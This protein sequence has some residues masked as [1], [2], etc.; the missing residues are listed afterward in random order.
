MRD[1]LQQSEQ[2]LQ[3]L[4][5]ATPVGIAYVKDRVFQKVNDAM[6]DLYGYSREELIGQ[7]SRM[8]YATN[9]EY[10]EAGRHSYHQAMEINS[11]MV[12]TH[13]ITKQGDKIDILMGIAPLVQGDE[14]AG[15]VTVVLDITDRNK[16]IAALKESEERF[17]TIFNESP[18]VIALND[19]SNGGYVDVNRKF[20][21]IRNNSRESF[22]GKT[23]V[24][25]G[26]ISEE[27]N[28]RLQ[29][30]F[31]EKGEIDQEEISFVDLQGNAS[32]FLLYSKIVEITGK[33]H[34][35]SMLQDITARKNAEI[36]LADS[37]KRF[38]TV[39]EKAPIGISM[40]RDMRYIFSNT[41]HAQIFGFDDPLEIIGKSVVDMI[42]PQSQQMIVKHSQQLSS[43]DIASAQFETIGVR[44]DGTEFPYLVSATH[45]DLADGP[46]S[47][48]FGTDISERKHA[49]DLMIES[50]KMS[51]VAGMAAGMAHEVNNPLGIIAQDVQNM[52]R[53]LSTTLAANLRT[54]EELGL[55]LNLMAHYLEQRGIYNF[56]TSM[57]AAVK[58]ASVIISN[59]LKFSRQNSANKQLININDILEQSIKLASN[60][61]D[62]RKKYDFKNIT[63]LRNFYS[64][65]PAVEINTTEIEQV[66][67]NLLKNAAQAM[68]DSGTINPTVTI[69]TS[70]NYHDIIIT[71][72]DNGPGMSESVR[73][74]IF[75]PFFTTKDVGSGTG[76]GLSVSH[77]IITKNHGGALT[78]E[79]QI[80]HGAC[81]TIRLP[82]VKESI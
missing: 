60:D 68:F 43:K 50:E 81:F 53:R 23:S 9:V 47:I 4:F 5:L 38:R 62:L 2:E 55:D 44:K 51:M 56:I 15:F 82:L 34:S 41:A 31:M 26:F 66:F 35:I 65:L 32:F 6:C 29:N 40:V 49:L 71:I 42:A 75:D 73:K 8:L 14:T 67:I 39:I 77:T 45:L 3:S 13:T 64:N 12:E 54:A 22:L 57:H 48:S 80:D 74:K 10:E 21:E 33:P 79:S 46:V 58:R 24:E 70:H 27:E 28:L 59:M 61:Y 52:E 19:L 1:A 72:T 18:M 69:S 63:L 78:V 17:Q 36:A 11:V 25:S 37:E 76:L 30:I 7:S 20:C 16:V